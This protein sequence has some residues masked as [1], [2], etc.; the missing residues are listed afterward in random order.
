MRTGT[1]LA[2]QL[3]LPLQRETS[4]ERGDFI[5]SAANAEAVRLVDAWPNWPG[6]CLALCGPAGS[7]KTHLAEAWARRA[8]ATQVRPGDDVSALRGPFLIEDADDWPDQEALFHLINRAP[9]EGGLLFTSRQRPVAWRVKVPDLRSR[10]NAITVAELDE[11]DDDVLGQVILKL[12]R[13]RNIRPTDDVL[14]YLLRR[15]ERSIP[16]AR[17]LVT[18]IDETADAEQR[19]VSRA[20]VRQILEIEAETPDLFP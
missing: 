7:G 15:I 10:L 11:P 8:A 12:F 16:A 18:L 17:D 13:E 4:H 1:V 19:P 6:G 20:L 3:R 5:V 14:P 9:L 2:R